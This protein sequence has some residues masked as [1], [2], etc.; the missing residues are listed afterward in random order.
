MPNWCHNTLTV[1]GEAS[2]LARFVEDVRPSEKSLRR[3]WKAWQKWDGK[4]PTFKKYV[5]ETRARQPLSFE[6][7]V[8][9]P[10]DEELRK[11]ERHQ[12]CTM[13][14]AVGTLPSSQAEASDRGSKWYP[15][16][17]PSEREDRTCNVC[18]GSGEERVGMEGWYTWRTA[19]WGTK[20]DASFGEPFM[21]LGA[22]DAD[23]DVTTSALGET[24]TP[25]V[26]VYKF[27]TAWAPPVPFVES[28]SELYPELE[29]VLRYGE[30]G[31]G[32]AGSVRVVGGV[33]V[34]DEELEV[35]DVL[36]PEEMWF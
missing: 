11:R 35:E 36:A 7:L 6:A 15:W 20:W 9:Q 29:F 22:D 31:N 4:R 17:D 28:A 10:S 14:G 26:A 24:L 19:Y 16:M 8:P 27:D 30:P 33:I 18:G 25:T 13:C 5:E 21:A 34:E 3:S 1:T 2:E 12:P 23:V 32:I